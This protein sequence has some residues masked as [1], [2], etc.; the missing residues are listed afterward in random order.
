M[1]TGEKVLR[2]LEARVPVKAAGDGKYRMNS[3]FRP[4]ANSH[5]F[6]VMIH[7]GG[8]TG[9]FKD[10][11]HGEFGSLYTLA[12]L[13]GIEVPRQQAANTKRPYAGLDEY[14]TVHGVPGDVFRAARWRECQQTDCNGKTRPALEFITETGP[15]YRFL[16]GDSPSYHS[17]AGYKNCWYGLK[18]AVKRASESN[19]PLVLCN[20]ATSVVV[21]HHYGVP[22]F[23]VSGGTDKLPEN[24]LTELRQSWGGDI[25]IA[26]DC[27]KQGTEATAKLHEQLPTASVVDLALTAG[28]DLADLC[29][30]YQD[31]A[32]GEL[33]R[34]A[35]RFDMY[36]ETQDATDL[37]Q[38]LRELATAQKSDQPVS[39]D[40]LLDKAQ[41][42]IDHLRH[43]SDSVHPLSFAELVSRNHKALVER[44]ANPCA[45][46]GL[47]THLPSLDKI[48]G[49]WVGGR[50]H[51]LYGDTNMGKSTLAVSIAIEWLNQG[52]GLIVPTESPAHA[53]LDKL[54][55][56][57]ARVPYDAIET[58]YMTDAQYNAMEIAYTRLEMMN[59]HILDAGSP[60][61]AI[62]GAALRKGMVDYGYKWC[63]IDSLSKMKVPGES[64][65]YNTT[66]LVMDAAQ[67]LCTETCI[68]FLATCQVGRNLK[69]RTVKLPQ[70][71]DA[72]GAG[73]V[74]Q[75][76]DV[77]LTL[78]R[79]EHYVK[80]GVSDP[81]PKYPANGALITCVKHRWKDAAGKSVML[82]FVG[83]AGFYELATE[84]KKAA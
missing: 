69:E 58:G 39:L 68:P 17:P 26:M 83:G 59:C 74:E 8:E 67:D 23:A 29:T 33:K 32:I 12:E 21:A 81:D 10:H 3:P 51:V 62:L 50:L 14:A 78:Y 18:M 22:A 13:L 35:V 24:L 28:G 57:M 71:N 37:A 40:A 42:Q 63:V 9:A 20:G 82:T 31:K 6:S 54:A 44:K 48:V 76:A 64:D 84:Q 80:L 47:H 73:T 79:H 34:R 66:R 55:A 27:D 41:T 1:T 16:D 56:C 45:V 2:A 5:S 19:Q 75:N 15:R 49:G 72:L 11:S 61:P 53:Y 36:K 77:V 38:S 7:P 65:I 30:L 70:V 4:G 43:K 60:T 46:R 52:T 25:L